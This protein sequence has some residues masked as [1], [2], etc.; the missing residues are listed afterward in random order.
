VIILNIDAEIKI[1]CKMHNINLHAKPYSLVQPLSTNA[2][3]P[4]K[5]IPAY[6]TVVPY[7]AII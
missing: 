7:I 3:L 6:A 4:S 5:Q 1:S 2:T